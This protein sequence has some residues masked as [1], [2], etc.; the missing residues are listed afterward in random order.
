MKKATLN[1]EILQYLNMLE[2][3]SQSKVLSFV[4]SL[5]KQPIKKQSNRELLSFAGAFSLSDLDEMSTAIAEGC[6]TIDKHEW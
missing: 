4:K 3:S 6:E 1:I 5:F 2:K